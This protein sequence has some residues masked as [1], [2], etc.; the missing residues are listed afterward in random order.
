MQKDRGKE[1]AAASLFFKR[2]TCS[3]VYRSTMRDR[4]NMFPAGSSCRNAIL[5]KE[6]LQ[7]RGDFQRRRT[8]PMA[9]YEGMRHFAVMT[10]RPPC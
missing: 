4:V 2:L 1:A 5:P 9:Q 7:L 10:K 6:G 8:V 3:A